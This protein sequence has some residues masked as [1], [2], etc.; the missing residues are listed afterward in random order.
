MRT[1][2]N[3]TM[4][5]VDK[6]DIDSRLGGAD[7]V[8]GRCHKF[9]DGVR[10]LSTRPAIPRLVPGLIPVKQLWDLVRHSTHTAAPTRE[11]D[12]LKVRRTIE[13]THRLPP[14]MNCT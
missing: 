14:S 10:Q 12:Q 3:G 6:E 4:A 1:G 2:L 7:H 11:G 13:L 8:F 9:N 5:H